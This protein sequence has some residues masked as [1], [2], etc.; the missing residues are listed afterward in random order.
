M[1]ERAY[2]NL[3]GYGPLE[4]LQRPPR[5]AVAV[6]AMRADR[7]DNLADELIR[8]L[9]LA[10]VALQAPRNHKRST[11]RTSNTRTY[12]YAIVAVLAC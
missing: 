4:P 3:A 6:A 1:A 9:F 5:L 2:R 10:A 7:L 11:S 12:R 8:H